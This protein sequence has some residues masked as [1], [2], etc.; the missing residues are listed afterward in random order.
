MHIFFRFTGSEIFNAPSKC[1]VE[2]IKIMRNKLEKQNL[3]KLT[4]KSEVS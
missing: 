2:T 1:A 3:K 4:L